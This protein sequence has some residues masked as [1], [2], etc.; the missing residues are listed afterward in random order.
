MI[1]D[2]S[3]RLVWIYNKIFEIKYFGGRKLRTNTM[4]FQSF[5]TFKSIENK[6]RL[7]L[8]IFVFSTR[9]EY[10]IILYTCTIESGQ[11]CF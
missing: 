5:Y 3:F 4:L 9:L 10:Y 6:K 11:R 1:K 2:K 8:Q 7:T